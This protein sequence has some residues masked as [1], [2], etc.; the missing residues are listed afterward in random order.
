MGVTPQ[1]V[2]GGW[3]GAEDRSVRLYTSADGARQALPIFAGF[4]NKVY[5]NPSLGIT[6]EDQFP[7]PVG[8]VV[9]N[10][11]SS[12]SDPVSSGYI[13]DRGDDGFE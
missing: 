7:L 6:Q 4:M 5:A 13:I 1:L 2:A 3:V 8:S 10:C 9:Y 11:D 12:G